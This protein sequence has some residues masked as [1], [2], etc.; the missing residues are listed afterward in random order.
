MTAK[1]LI[2]ILKKVPENAQIVVPSHCSAGCYS[3]GSSQVLFDDEKVQ[4]GT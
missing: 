3:V 1:D 4:I 2:K